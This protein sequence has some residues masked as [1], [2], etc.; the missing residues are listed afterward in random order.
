MGAGK[1]GPRDRLYRKGAQFIG[2]EVFRNPDFL[3][4]QT[5]PDYWC[6]L[7]SERLQALAADEDARLTLTENGPLFRETL[8]LVDDVRFPNEVDTLRRWGARLIFIDAY[9]RLQSR[10]G[11]AWRRHE[12]EKMANDYTFG[13][14]TD[15]YF[16]CVL[17]N[18]DTEASF[19]RTVRSM[20]PSWTG[21]TAQG[22][23]ED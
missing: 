8:V 4:G 13:R 17:T 12:S 15:E 19:R 9:R 3:P 22:R 20:A 2:T 16:D 10:M 23:I 11:E 5:G 6:N 14:L 21:L 1:G 7:L 18:S